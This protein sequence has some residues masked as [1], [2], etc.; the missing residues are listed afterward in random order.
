MNEVTNQSLQSVS[1]R[2]SSVSSK[3][4][5]DS[6]SESGKKLPPDEQKISA[7][8]VKTTDVN[9][10]EQALPHQQVHEDMKEVVAQMNEYT[11]SMQRNI[12]FDVDDASGRTVVTVKDRTTQEVIRQIPDETFLKMAQSLK[13]SVEAGTEEPLHL[14]TAK[15]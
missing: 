7:T 3:P 12:Q 4:K 15:A 1:V 5:A 8:Q 6:V 14:I 11:Q 2:T 13:E 9:V 10:D